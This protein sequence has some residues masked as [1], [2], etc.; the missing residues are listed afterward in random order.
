MHG[1]D[2]SNWQGAKVCMLILALAQAPL[3]PMAVA[4]LTARPD[5]G[6]RG[7]SAAQARAGDP[8]LGRPR[9]VCL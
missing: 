3:N 5:L 2:L 7:G 8:S 9:A 1:G 4:N 6:R